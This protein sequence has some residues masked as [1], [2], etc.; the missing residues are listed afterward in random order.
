M[1]NLNH[2]GTNDDCKAP[3]AEAMLMKKENVNS[4][5]GYEKAVSKAEAYATVGDNVEVFQ[6]GVG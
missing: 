3:G 6:A 2:V 4:K 1:W 5:H